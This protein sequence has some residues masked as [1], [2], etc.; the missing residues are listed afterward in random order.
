MFPNLLLFITKT[1]NWQNVVKS[2]S[3]LKQEA[4]LYM[5]KKGE[6]KAICYIDETILKQKTN[7]VLTGTR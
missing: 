2:C 1:M 4:V 5:I 6:W 7:F 3:D